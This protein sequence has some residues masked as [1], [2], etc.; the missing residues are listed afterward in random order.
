MRR[1]HIALAVFAFLAASFCGR[2]AQADTPPEAE[3]QL[4]LEELSA[5]DFSIARGAEIYARDVAA[6]VAT[7]VLLEHPAP[8]T[9]GIRG[10]VVTPI[11]GPPGLYQVTFVSGKSPDWRIAASF[12]ID[13]GEVTDFEIFEDAPA[14]FSLNEEQAAAFEAQLSASETL[15]GLRKCSATVNTVVISTPTGH[16]AYFLTPQASMNEVQFGTHYRVPVSADG[17]TGEPFSFTKSC[18]VVSKSADLEGS[19][20]IMVW[21]T[22][23]AGPVPSEIHVFKSLEHSTPVAVLTVSNDRMWEVNGKAIRLLGNADKK[24]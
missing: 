24:D 11:V 9:L 10:W 20:P 5:I 14:R 1:L 23:L 13:R 21:V 6:W 3:E 15:A 8:G 22:D 16:D 4:S 12:T 2:F 19:T 7:D 18:L 17:V